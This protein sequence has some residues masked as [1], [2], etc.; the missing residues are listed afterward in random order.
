MTTTAD[1]DAAPA[2]ERPGTGPAKVVAAVAAGMFL[3]AAL[4]YFVLA[5]LDEPSEA[6]VGFLQDMI[7]HHEN[8][9]AASLVVSDNDMPPA[10][11]SFAQE[12]VIFQ[13]YEI[14]LME[15]TLHQWN[16][17]RTPGETSMG[18]MGDAHPPAEM[19]GMI[20]EEGLDE[21]AEAEGEDAAALW[22]AA[23][24]RHHLA[25]IE[26]AE[27]LG[28]VV[29]DGY[30]AELAARIADNQRKEIEEYSGVRTSLG[31]PV[32]E[33][34]TDPPTLDDGHTDHGE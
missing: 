18:W 27:A 19:P 22:L 21:L 8:G 32:P 23:M 29:A 10:V 26:M 1:T 12:V 2:Q 14:G 25:G 30:V 5:R 20:S 11:R 7:V 28:E 6:E 24:S 3:A 34:Y 13:Q 4:T 9:V 16:E 31:L 17:P 15:A 33:G